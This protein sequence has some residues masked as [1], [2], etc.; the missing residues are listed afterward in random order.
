MS[1]ADL[2]KLAMI[3]VHNDPQLKE[4][5]F[6]LILTIH[7]ELMGECPKENAFKCSERLSKLMCETAE[8]ALEGFPFKSDACIN[9]RW[10]GNEVTEDTIEQV[11]QSDST[12]SCCNDLLAM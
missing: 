1:S 12:E 2:T 6:K 4:W 10:Y 7:D 5:G 11:E 3:K 9:I 8:N